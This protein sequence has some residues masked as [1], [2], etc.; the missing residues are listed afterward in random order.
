[1]IIGFDVGRPGSDRTVVQLREGTKLVCV[2]PDAGPWKLIFFD[3]R[4]LAASQA[5]GLWEL[6]DGNLE[7]VIP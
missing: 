6:V 2:C 7:K 4:L 1:M 3:G 5:S